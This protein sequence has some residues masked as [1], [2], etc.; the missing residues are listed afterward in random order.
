M[1]PLHR[2]HSFKLIH[3]VK[4]AG[5]CSF[6]FYVREP[7]DRS[8]IY[9]ILDMWSLVDMVNVNDIEIPSPKFSKE[10]T[11][12]STF[13][14]M[15][16]KIFLIKLGFQLLTNTDALWVKLIRSK[17]KLHGVL[18][19]STDRSNCSYIWRS[20][21][22]MWPDA[23]K[24]V[25]WSLET[26]KN[27]FQI[28]AGGFSSCWQLIWKTKAP[29]RIRSFLWV[30]WQDRLLTNGERMRRHMMSECYALD[31]NHNSYVFASSN[32]CVQDLAV[33]GHGWIKMNSDGAVS[34]NYDNASIRGLFR[35]VN[36]HWLSRYSLKVS[37]EMIF[38]IE[39]LAIL[40]DLRIA[41]EKGYRQLEIECDNALLVESVLKGS[42][43][44][45]NLVELHLINVYLKRNWK[46][47]IR[48]ISRSQNMA[49]DQ[50]ATCTYD[51]QFG[52]KHY[53]DPQFW[54][55]RFYNKMVI[56]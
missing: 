17:Y 23:I 56:S 44:S 13:Y 41:W 9:S 48:H 27:F 6:F 54:F 7:N 10:W 30:F 21:A 2:R 11:D 39:A 15:I 26:C 47:R 42:A 50:M 31:V 35:D 3:Q 29:Q 55:K 49:A 43:A 18:P 4:S 16:N 33:T 34:M 40:E 5:N 25:Y 1:A 20:L 53:E 45:S 24:N 52:L 38:R 12:E 22:N 14:A 19:N 36:G 28:N 8:T 32:T 46:T 37:K 51:N